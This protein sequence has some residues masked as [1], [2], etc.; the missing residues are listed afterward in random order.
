GFRIFLT[1]E[2]SPKLPANL[3]VRSHVLVFE[4][5]NG[6]QPSLLRSLEKHKSKVATS[7][8][9]KGPR[10]LPRLHFIASW[11]HAVIIERLRYSP[12]GWAKKYEFSEGDFIRTVDTM[13]QWVAKVSDGRDNVSPK[14]LPWKAMF[15]LLGESVYGGRID[16]E[17][18]QHL[19]RSFLSQFLSP[20]VYSRN[21]PLTPK[22]EG[23][24]A[25]TISTGFEPADFEEWIMNMPSNQTPV[26][27]GLPG[28]SQKMIQQQQGEQMLA[29]LVKITDI[30]EEEGVEGVDDDEDKAAAAPAGQ[31]GERKDGAFVPE[32]ARRLQ[33]TASSW[34]G[35]MYEINR[36]KLHKQLKEA[37]AKD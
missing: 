22:R 17:F 6:I 19:V 25:L 31:K 2:I 21:F 29:D 37:V 32:W 3:L 8:G 1:S 24:E 20:E 28:E 14:D 4:P 33:S 16:N 11:I 15:T 10:E 13:D 35:E 9:A 30:F 12:L 27:L 7:G 26:W 34:L 5:S 23:E 36:G 18:D